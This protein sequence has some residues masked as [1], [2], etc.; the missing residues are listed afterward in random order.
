[1][2]EEYYSNSKDT[3]LAVTYDVTIS[4]STEVT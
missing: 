2:N 4:A 3:T 1:M